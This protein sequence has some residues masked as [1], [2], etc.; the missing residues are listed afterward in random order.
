[1]RRPSPRETGRGDGRRDPCPRSRRRSPP[2]RPAWPRPPQAARAGPPA[3]T[4]PTAPASSPRGRASLRLP[5]AGVLA[6]RVVE[7]QDHL[8]DP[9]LIQA[10]LPGRHRRAPGPRFLRQPRAPLGDA[11]E[12]VGLLEH[13]DRPRVLEVGRR[14]IERGREAAVPVQVVAVAVDAVPD[15]DLAPGGDLLR[16]RRLVLAERVV[17]PLDA[18]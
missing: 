10:V 5:A 3:T 7:V 2:T 11:P 16:K 12:E 4:R 18:E 13:G 15:V 17:E 9:G 14:R 1:G 8:P 6:G